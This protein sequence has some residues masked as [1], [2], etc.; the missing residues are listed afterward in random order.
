MSPTQQQEDDVHIIG[1]H[2]FSI[3]VDLLDDQSEPLES[4]PIFLSFV[5]R[6]IHCQSIKKKCKDLHI[7]L[8]YLCCGM[9]PISPSSLYPVPLI[10]SL[11]I[12]YP[13]L[14]IH[15]VCHST[16]KP[17]LLCPFSILFY[18]YFVV[19]VVVL[20]FAWYHP[21]NYHWEML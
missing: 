16:D 12:L 2:L 11:S 5:I 3:A 8:H 1:T 7:A 20:K 15:C 13:M 17:I 14:S 4:Q 18:L 10:I 21:F 6:I 19:N 9:F